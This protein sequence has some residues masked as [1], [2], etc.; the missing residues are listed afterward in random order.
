MVV[1]ELSAGRLKFVVLR[2]SKF[3][4]RSARLVSFRLDTKLTEDDDP[5]SD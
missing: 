4:Y 3:R 1:D 2:G 5:T